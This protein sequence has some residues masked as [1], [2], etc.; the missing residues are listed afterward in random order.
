MNNKYIKFL[1]IQ[2]VKYR[3][4]QFIRLAKFHND[5]SE[6]H[7]TTKISTSPHISRYITSQYIVDKYLKELDPF[8]RYILP[9]EIVL[10]DEFNDFFK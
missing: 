10:M 5:D 9:E 8:I 6:V 3:G 1:I 4:V 2:G 7:V